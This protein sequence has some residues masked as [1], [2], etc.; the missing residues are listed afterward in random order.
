MVMV[1]QAAQGRADQEPALVLAAQDPGTRVKAIKEVIISSLAVEASSRITNR[2]TRLTRN[3]SVGVSIMFLQPALTS[4]T[5]RCASGRL[6]QSCRL[7]R[8][9]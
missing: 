6:M 4:E 8:S 2:G 9:I 5:E 3:S 7:S 1:R